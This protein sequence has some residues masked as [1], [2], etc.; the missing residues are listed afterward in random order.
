MYGT[1][2]VCRVVEVRRKYG[3]VICSGFYTTRPGASPPCPQR[4]PGRSGVGQSP[5]QGARRGRGRPALQRPTP[6]EAPNPS[7]ICAVLYPQPQFCTQLLLS[8]PSRRP[9]APHVLRWAGRSLLTGPAAAGCRVSASGWLPFAAYLDLA[10]HLLDGGGGRPGGAPSPFSGGRPPNFCVCCGWGRDCTHGGYN[11]RNS[12]RRSPLDSLNSRL[13]T[14]GLARTP[15]LPPRS[16]QR[17]S[18]ERI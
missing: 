10:G 12:R 1:I 3:V 17:V 5:S 9:E 4:T 15:G 13:V 14:I 8:W 16:Y 2:G 11:G 18:S 7:S 6:V